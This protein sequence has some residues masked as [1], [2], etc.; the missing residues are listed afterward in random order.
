MGGKTDIETA[1]CHS[2]QRKGKGYGKHQMLKVAKNE[3]NFAA[4]FTLNT[5]LLHCEK[6]KFCHFK[7]KL[8]H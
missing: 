7:I 1:G 3:Q 8:S 6:I 2:R 4:A 5:I